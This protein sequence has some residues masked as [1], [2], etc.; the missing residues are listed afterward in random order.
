[1]RVD[2]PGSR[3]LDN[4]AHLRRDLVVDEDSYSFVPGFDFLLRYYKSKDKHG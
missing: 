3:E 2:V 4:S 1:M